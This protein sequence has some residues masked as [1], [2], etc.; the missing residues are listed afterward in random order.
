M[1]A[2]DRPVARAEPRPLALGSPVPVSVPLIVA[3]ADDA[4]GGD[5]YASPRSPSRNGRGCSVS[6]AVLPRSSRPT[7][8]LRK[9]ASC[10]H[11]ARQLMLA[12]PHSLVAVPRDAMVGAS[13]GDGC[14]WDT[15]GGQ[16][17]GARAA[18]TT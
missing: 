18:T 5:A 11:V 9:V 1:S 8:P 16:L 10:M 7:V 3:G 17:E 13:G 15:A 12:L 6:E 14:A 2:R 4:T